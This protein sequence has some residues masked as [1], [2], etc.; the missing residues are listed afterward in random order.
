M[1]KKVKN[2]EVF[3]KDN[4]PDEKII[5]RFLKK[6][7]KTTFLRE[8]VER[9]R[10]ISHSEKRRKKKSRKLRLARKENEQNNNLN[11]KKVT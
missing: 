5:R 10:F 6:S 4:E 9:M 11:D 8:Y 3:S 7:S 1:S 2:F